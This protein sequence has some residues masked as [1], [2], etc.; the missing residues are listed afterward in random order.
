MTQ[1]YVDEYIDLWVENIPK[2]L[3]EQT[4]AIVTTYRYLVLKHGYTKRSESR[5]L[6]TRAIVEVAND[7]M[8][9][10]YSLTD[11]IGGWIDTTSDNKKVR[12]EVEEIY[13]E[14]LADEEEVK[15]DVCRNVLL[16]AVKVYNKRHGYLGRHRRE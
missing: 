6:F 16:K 13:F 10:E 5:D 14:L 1:E 3:K 15:Y 12:K 11:V 2:D 7:N 9:W 8:P 4:D